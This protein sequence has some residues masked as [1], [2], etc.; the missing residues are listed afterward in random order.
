MGLG[1]NDIEA[2]NCAGSLLLQSICRYSSQSSAVYFVVVVFTGRLKVGC[3]QYSS[4][5]LGPVA[6]VHSF[7]VS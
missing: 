1:R 5:M 7:I 2:G 3:K 4:S 6:K